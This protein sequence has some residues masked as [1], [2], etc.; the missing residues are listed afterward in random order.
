MLALSSIILVGEVFLYL[1]IFTRWL[2]LFLAVEGLAR[3]PG[4]I[5]PDLDINGNWVTS[6]QDTP[7]YSR[8]YFSINPSED[9]NDDTVVNFDDDNRKF[10]STIGTSIL[11]A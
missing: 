10:T 9:Y 7:N 4:V 6:L 8:I 5:S 1:F 11:H 2:T 3:C